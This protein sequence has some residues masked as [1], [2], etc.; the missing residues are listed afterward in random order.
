MTKK[1]DKKIK[2]TPAKGRLMLYWAGKKPLEYVKGYPAQLTEVYDPYGKSK[3]H[4]IPKYDEIEKNW[5]NLLFE[6]DNKD[7]LALLLE[8]GFRGKIDLIY[9]DP[10]FASNADYL[11]KV[12]LRWFDN[13]AI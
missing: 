12:Q 9:I 3:F 11:R 10:P 8:N 7:V 4:K 6:G 2:I 5:H 1:P 13:R